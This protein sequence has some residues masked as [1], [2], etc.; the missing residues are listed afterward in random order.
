MFT[1]SSG[2]PSRRPFYY[3]AL[4]GAQNVDSANGGILL[5]AMATNEGAAAAFLLIADASGNLF[6]LAVPPK[7][8]QTLQP[9]PDGVAYLGQ[10]VITAS[11]ALDVTV[12]LA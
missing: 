1:R 9:L 2:Q 6:N 7:Q 3:A 10:L 12:M 11:A 8:S 4:S 5:G